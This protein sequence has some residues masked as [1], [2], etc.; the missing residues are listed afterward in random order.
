[1]NLVKHYI[2]KYV[3][4]DVETHVF[5]TSALVGWAWLLCPRQKI[6][7]LH[8]FDRWM[9]GTQSLSGYGET[10]I[11]DPTQTLDSSVVK[12]IAIC[13]YQLHYYED[14]CKIVT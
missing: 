8:P 4:V 12:H 1:V 9:G 2:K 14:I 5:L 6:I 10:K 13:Y 3:E 7:Q 11:L